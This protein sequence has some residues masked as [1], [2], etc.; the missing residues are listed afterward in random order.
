ML[1]GLHTALKYFTMG[2]LVGL[3]FARRKADE[4]SS[5]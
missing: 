2:L 1:K 4:V 5:V 3:L